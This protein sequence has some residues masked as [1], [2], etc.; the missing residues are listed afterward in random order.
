MFQLIGVLKNRCILKIFVNF[1]FTVS[2]YS[3]VTEFV[4]VWAPRADVPTIKRPYY[5]VSAGGRQTSSVFL[6]SSGLS[7]HCK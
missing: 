1:P 6:V 2:L 7:L 5:L 3:S 4:L